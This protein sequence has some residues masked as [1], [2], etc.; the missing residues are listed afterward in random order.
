M[1]KS[2]ISADMCGNCERSVKFPRS[3]PSWKRKIYP[4]CEK[5]PNKTNKSIKLRLRGTETYM[6]DEARLR[7]SPPALPAHGQALHQSAP[8]ADTGPQRQR[9]ASQEAFPAQSVYSTASCD[10]EHNRYTSNPRH[11][12]VFHSLH[13]HPVCHTEMLRG[14]VF[15][16][17]INTRFLLEEDRSAEEI[18]EGL[19]GPRLHRKSDN[20]VVI[21]QCLPAASIYCISVSWL[22]DF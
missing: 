16:Q 8:Q 6:T 12:D 13:K 7:Q 14:W 22:A 20:C 3:P 15:V 9:E 18:P 17:C 11:W 2:I 19:Q 10:R 4:F 1:I 21:H 5:A